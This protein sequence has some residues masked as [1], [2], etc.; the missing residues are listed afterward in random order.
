M[1][2]PN[3]PQQQDLKK[4]FK[5]L[6]NIWKIPGMIGATSI[7]LI[8]HLGKQELRMTIVFALD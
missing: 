8:M 4:K 7:A 1:P 2:S 3:W 6:L 5:T